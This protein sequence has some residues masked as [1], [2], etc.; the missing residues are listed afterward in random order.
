MV[1]R[2]TAALQFIESLPSSSVLADLWPNRSTRNRRMDLGRQAFCPLPTANA[3]VHLGAGA[4]GSLNGCAS[5]LA[6]ILSTAK[7]FASHFRCSFCQRRRASRV[8]PLAFA[9]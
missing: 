2:T 4:T 7:E 5:E 9:R 8:R 1:V 6:V 3:Q